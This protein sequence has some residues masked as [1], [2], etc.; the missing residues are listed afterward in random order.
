MLSSEEKA[1]LDNLY[2]IMTLN[3]VIIKIYLLK[4]TNGQ[5]GDISMQHLKRNLNI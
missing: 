4:V 1:F 2:N 3:Q 5:Y